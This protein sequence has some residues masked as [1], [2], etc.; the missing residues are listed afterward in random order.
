[1]IIKF[2]WQVSTKGLH[3]YLFEVNGHLALVQ[4]YPQMN[5]NNEIINNKKIHLAIH[6]VGNNDKFS[7]YFT[8][9]QNHI[10]LMHHAIV[11][12]VVLST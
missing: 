5:K 6:S 10:V 4:K 12:Y 7:F 8:V 2:S 3:L 11:Y 1:M 9:Y